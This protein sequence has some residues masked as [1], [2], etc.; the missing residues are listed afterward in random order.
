MSSPLHPPT[1]PPTHNQTPPPTHTTPPPPHTQPYLAVL[2]AHT[3]QCPASCLRCIR[4]REPSADTHSRSARQPL[5]A[6]CTHD[7]QPHTQCECV[8]TEHVYVCFGGGLVQCTGHSL[9]A[10]APR[11]AAPASPC[12]DSVHK[13]GNKQSDCTDRWSNMEQHLVGCP[14][15]SVR[16]INTQYT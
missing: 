16:N 2:V 8:D 14:T 6:P 7:T 4:S 10:H 5:Q 3:L 9:P 13:A 12:S 15:Q 11:H 1:H